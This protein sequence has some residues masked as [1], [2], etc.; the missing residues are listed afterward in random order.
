MEEFSPTTRKAFHLSG[1]DSSGITSAFCRLCSKYDVRFL[2]LNQ[3]LVHGCLSVNV[4]LQILATDDV[5]LVAEVEA[6]AKATAFHL[7]ITELPAR[8]NTNAQCG[9]F[10]TVIGKE[11]T[12]AALPEIIETLK[13]HQLVICRMETI[14][15]QAMIGVQLRA[16]KDTISREEFHAVRRDL[17]AKCDTLNVDIAVQ[18]DDIYRTSKRLLCM[19][20]DSTFVKGE[21]IDEL[22]EMCGVKSQV[23]A[24]T[25]RAM[26]GELD[27]EASLRL[28][29]SLLK[30]LPMARALELCDRFELTPGADDLVRMA[31]R[32]GMRVGLV[33]GGFD[34]FV[35]RLKKQFDLDF[36]F[37]NELEVKDGKLTGE[38]IGTVVDSARKAQLLK[39]MAHVFGINLAQTI[40]AGDGANDILM[41]QTAGLGIAYQAKP[42]LAEVAGTRFSKNDRLDTLFY[43]MGL[44]SKKLIGECG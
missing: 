37:A 20:V 15:E 32:V 35:A 8:Y 17:L 28:R 3:S 4:E 44:D 39:D 18:R 29:V 21:F 14:G 25:A 33:S 13:A 16:T 31:K 38:L 42:R 6:W 10:T 12:G 7:V 19:D 34:F 41:L 26:Q 36:A 5:Q 1:Q 40:A 23:A 43:L 22:A 2:H 11:H 24:I 9:L 30:G 27:F